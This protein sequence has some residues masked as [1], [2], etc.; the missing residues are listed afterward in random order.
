[1]Q[2]ELAPLAAR[3]VVWRDRSVV[4]FFHIISA[5]FLFPSE[6]F[7]PHKD[8]RNTIEKARKALTPQCIITSARCCFPQGFHQVFVN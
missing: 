1:M 2:G 4:A 5:S 6:Y 3:K 7:E 8:N